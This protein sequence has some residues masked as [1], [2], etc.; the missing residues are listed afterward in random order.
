[1]KPTNRI[2]IGGPPLDP[3]DE[4]DAC[5]RCGGWGWIDGDDLQGDCPQC[6]GDDAEPNDYPE[7]V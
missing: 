1:M 6:Q 3:P 2:Y 5:D 7:D 4:P